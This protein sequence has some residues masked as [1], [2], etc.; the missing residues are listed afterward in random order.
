MRGCA[1]VPGF[2]C[3]LRQLSYTDPMKRTDYR[4]YRM[5][6]NP[7]F[8]GPADSA[9][10]RLAGI[11][12][13]QPISLKRSLYRSAVRAA[14]ITR[15]DRFVSCREENPIVNYPA[16]NF[17]LWMDS[18]ENK[19]GLGELSA[20]VI[21]PPQIDRGRVYVHLFDSDCS[22]VGFAKISF[23]DQNDISIDS[24]AK[25][26]QS[27]HDAELQTFCVPAVLDYQS[28]SFEQ[29]AV[30]VTQPIP[31]DAKPL[32]K[33]L[34]S[35]PTACVDE[36]SG[37][38]RPIGPH[39]F[40]SLSWWNRFLDGCDGFSPEF[41][42]ELKE[43]NLANTDC[44][45]SHGDFGT[46]NMVKEPNGDLWVYDWEESCE[47]APILA[48]EISYFLGVHRSSNPS[49]HQ[50]LFERF[51]AH[52]FDKNNPQRRVDI[53]LALAFRSIVNRP[54]TDLIISR[55]NQL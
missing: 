38:Y 5:G 15:L 48:D 47:D 23:N 21:W 54:S 22:P 31:I 45:R 14:T 40:E 37:E 10:T 20:A 18:I 2:L 24:E 7:T 51:R 9:A 32:R 11:A 1:I 27:L 19:L 8:A 39:G 16:F 13:Y 34:I 17:F 44:C 53:M 36:I 29:H 6:G 33:N 25:T 28:A 55:W 50:L 46:H 43:A 30:L 41:V 12:R 52:F 26:L 4:I 42:R 49:K 3:V 35:Y